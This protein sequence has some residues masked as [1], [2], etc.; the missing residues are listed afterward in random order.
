MLAGARA[1]N[2]TSGGF[3]ALVLWRNRLCLCFLH[4][5]QHFPAM[6][7]ILYSSP[8]ALRS[9]TSARRRFRHVRAI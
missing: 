5:M 3:N 4:C 7:L 8:P 6:L 1:Q 2:D 9:L